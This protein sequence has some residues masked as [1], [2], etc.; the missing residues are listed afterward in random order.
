M[1]R[2][3]VDALER[4]TSQ[5]LA[6][7]HLDTTDCLPLLTREPRIT[8]AG[9]IRCQ[10]DRLPPQVVELDS[11]C[12]KLPSNRQC[13]VEVANSCVCFQ[14]FRHLGSSTSRCSSSL[15]CRVLLLRCIHEQA[16]NTW[17]SASLAAAASAAAGT[18]AVEK[19][20]DP[21][22][23]QKL[24]S[25]TAP[26]ARPAAEG[27]HWRSAATQQR[28][29]PRASPCS[30]SWPR[31]AAGSRRSLCG[32]TGSRRSNRFLGAPSPL[33]ASRGRGPA[34][35]RRPLPSCMPRSAR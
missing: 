18:A 27:S 2:S 12:C 30:R 4:R 26:T 32:S 11:C 19:Q 7:P 8:S 24:S 14:Y 29:P 13:N 10:S 22:R 15:C 25:L 33:P 17:S 9:Q 21:R 20:A 28:S 35:S 23:Y 1:G 31:R 3:H 16:T 5:G 34:L 6:R